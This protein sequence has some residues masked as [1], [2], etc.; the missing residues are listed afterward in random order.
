MGAVEQR[1]KIMFAPAKTF[2]QVSTKL[3]FF[4]IPFLVTE[5]RIFPWLSQIGFIS[6]FVRVLSNQNKY[7]MLE[8][9]IFDNLIPLFVSPAY[10]SCAV[11]GRG[12]VMTRRKP[13]FGV[14]A[15]P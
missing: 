14:K 5:K 11:D 1:K 10:Q 2:R 7:N 15:F 4:E 9:I 8:D 3:S 12:D 13:V 6:S